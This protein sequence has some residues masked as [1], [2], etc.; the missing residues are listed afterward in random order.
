MDAEGLNDG[1]MATGRISAGMSVYAA[2]DPILSYEE[3]S[4]ASHEI[5]QD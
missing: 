2:G 4:S 3:R 1:S 5:S